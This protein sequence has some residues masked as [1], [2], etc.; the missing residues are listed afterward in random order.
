MGV[1]D[2][3]SLSETFAVCADEVES[4]GILWIKLLNAVVNQMLSHSSF[5]SC[6]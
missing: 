3:S 2:Y 1:M 4:A 6:K 5:N